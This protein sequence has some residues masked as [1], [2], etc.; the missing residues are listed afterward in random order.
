MKISSF[1]SRTKNYLQFCRDHY[2]AGHKDPSNRRVHN[3]LNI[4]ADIAAPVAGIVTGNLALDSLGLIGALAVGAAS[5]GI[6]WSGVFA[7]TLIGHA[8]YQH[9][10]LKEVARG[11]LIPDLIGGQLEAFIALIPKSRKK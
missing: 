10:T 5:G 11:N 9:E 7:G 6:A 1:Y 4:G 2:N 8:K 3:V